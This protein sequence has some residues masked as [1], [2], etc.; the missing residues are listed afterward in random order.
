[1][2]LGIVAT[3][4]ALFII[5]VLR[6]FLTRFTH[7]DFNQVIPY[8]RPDGTAILAELMDAKLEKFL[9]LN[10][11]HRQFRREQL[12]RIRLADEYIG[13]RSHNA[14]IWQG[15]GDT[16]LSK[17][18]QTLDEEV[19]AAADALVLACVDYRIGGSAVQTQLHVWQF[20]LI[21]LP[22]ARVPRI[23]V[24]KTVDDFDLLDSYEKIQYAALALAELCGG[25]CYDRLLEAL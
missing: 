21:L 20:K 11:T 19:R 7:R 23:T 10:M 8:L 25:D 1:M 18:R 6:L 16:E 9:A 15:W 22:F 17:A 4:V 13:H 5:S 14:V 2:I 24:L 3:L 12:D